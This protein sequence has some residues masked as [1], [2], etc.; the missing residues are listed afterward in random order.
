MERKP[1]LENINN[2]ESEE[3]DMM[4]M[5]L[6]NVTHNSVGSAPHCKS[7]SYEFSSYLI[8]V[9]LFPHNYVSRNVY[10]LGKNLYI[11]NRKIINTHYFI[12]RQKFTLKSSWIFISQTGC[13]KW[14]K[15]KK[16]L[17]V[18]AI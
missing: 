17:L 8:T 9:P 3:E 7:T 13:K 14:E 5:S 4:M 2:M 15:K 18:N 12:L 10:Y 6:Y 16:E 1:S 11:K